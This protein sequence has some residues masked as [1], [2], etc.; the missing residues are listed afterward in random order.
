MI[1]VYEEPPGHLRLPDEANSIAGEP[2]DSL[3][4]PDRFER[5]DVV[6]V[7]HDKSTVM[8]YTWLSFED[9]WV[10]ESHLFL[11]LT[12]D[13]ATTYDAFVFPQYRGRGLYTRIESAA[14]AEAG[15]RG[16]KRVITCVES[17]NTNSL[18][19][20]LRLGKTQIMSLYSIHL[21]D[22]FSVHLARGRPLASRFYK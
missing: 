22:R 12:K 20:Q 17:Y 7:C 21:Y 1:S 18:K 8:G 15:R 14:L 4:L 10:G 5:G 6:V 2:F 3:T 9:L 19:T 16:R 13:E 11:S